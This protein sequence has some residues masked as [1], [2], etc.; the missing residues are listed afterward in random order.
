MANASEKHCYIKQ[1]YIKLK[2]HTLR[3]I[4]LQLA[5]QVGAE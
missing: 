5:A 4:Y 1:E 2:T 3:T